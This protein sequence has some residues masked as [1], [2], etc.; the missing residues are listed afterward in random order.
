M[1][2]WHDRPELNDRPQAF[3]LLRTPPKGEINGIVCSEEQIGVKLHFWKGR[4]V[5]CKGD[6]CEACKEGQN[7]RW[8]GY[9]YIWSPNSKT[10][11]IFEFTERAF[12][13]FDTYFT[14][15]GT[16]RGAK[17]TARRLS[18][19]PNG[20]VNITF[21]G[22]NYADSNLPQ[23]HSLR[24]VLLRMWEINSQIAMPLR[25]SQHDETLTGAI[26]KDLPGQKNFTP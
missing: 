16:L 18:K 24:E 21:A 15:H 6:L 13:A 2:I 9:V 3:T 26:T 19:R 5:P 25:G 10:T 7:P 4:S 22:G 11:A 23:P 1:T 8:K 14:E 17:M 20:P 12:S